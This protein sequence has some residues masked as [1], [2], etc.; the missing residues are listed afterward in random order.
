MI[1]KMGSADSYFPVPSGRCQSCNKRD[2]TQI[3]SAGGVLDVVHGFFAFRCKVCCI[4]EQLTHMKKM[5]AQI[6]ELEL[7][8][9]E[10]L[11]NDNEQD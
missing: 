6:P 3:W 11:K 9:E 10:L 1:Y 7:E 5:A 2:A 4:R 8:L